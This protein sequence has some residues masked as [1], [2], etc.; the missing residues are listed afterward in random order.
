MTKDRQNK[1]KGKKTVQNTESASEAS[2]AKM[3]ANHSRRRGHRSGLE[4]DIQR[5]KRVPS[6]QQETIPRAQRG[7]QQG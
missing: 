1:A 3:L 6:R 7:H 2:D 5:T 4:D